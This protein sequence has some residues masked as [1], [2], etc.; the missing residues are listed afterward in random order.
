MIQLYH[1]F[2][3][4]QNCL[5]QSLS[6][7]LEKRQLFSQYFL[8]LL[9]LSYKPILAVYDCIQLSGHFAVLVI[10]YREQFANDKFFRHRLN[11]FGQI[12]KQ[13]VVYLPKKRLHLSQNA[14]VDLLIELFADLCFYELVDVI[15][16]LL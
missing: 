15:E 14:I 8:I 3:G 13:R 9:Q 4:L 2:I 16:F 12:P 10:E 1:T 6:V 11:F 7:T 5:L